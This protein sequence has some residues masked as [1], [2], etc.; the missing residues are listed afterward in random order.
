MSEFVL[1]PHNGLHINGTK[2]RRPKRRKNK[3]VLNLPNVDSKPASPPNPQQCEPPPSPKSFSP[4][5]PSDGCK[6]PTK[7]ATLVESENWSLRQTETGSFE[8]N[9]NSINNITDFLQTLN[10]MASE[11]PQHQHIE[12]TQSETSH[13]SEGSTLKKANR[14]STMP[15]INFHSELYAPQDKNSTVEWPRMKTAL[16]ALLDDCVHYHLQCMNPYFPVR[17]RRLLMKWYSGLAEPTKDP[18]VL[19]ISTYFVRHIFMHHMPP[20]FDKIRDMKV[21]DAVQTQLALYTREALSDCFDVAHPHHIYALCLYNMNSKVPNHLKAFY[22]TIAVR[23]AL[24]LNIA[25]RHRNGSTSTVVDDEVE[26]NN[27]IWWC[28]FQIDHFLTESEIISCSIIEPT[29]DNHAALSKLV[30]PSPCSLDEPDEV[31]GSHLWNNILKLWLIRRRLEQ[32]FEELDYDNPLAMNMMSDKV[33]R[34]INIWS[35]ELPDIFQQDVALKPE[36]YNTMA[37]M[38]FTMGIERC[39]NRILLHRMFLPLD[40]MDALNPLQHRSALYAVESVVELLSMRRAVIDIAYCQTWPGDLKRAIEMLMICVKFQD[41]TVMTRSKLGLMR[42]LRLLRSMPETE[43]KEDMC[44]T[45]I[46]RIEQILSSWPE[47]PITSEQTIT[48]TPSSFNNAAIPSP[49]ELQYP[50][51]TR[52]VDA[53]LYRN[54]SQSNI[55]MGDLPADALAFLDSNIANC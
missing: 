46:A 22:H 12:E 49:P 32:E 38:C 53:E 18:L 54:E 37:Q 8:V 15:F 25:P 52:W 2:P 10:L 3:D 51:Y 14:K 7:S 29:S 47:S 19:A 50:S 33:E 44:V 16:P 9:I 40:K 36:N 4:L 17:P 48:S 23:M 30:R 31:T 11:D 39:T 5:P 42:A 21:L 13:D 26:L 24:E 34:E 28:L 35:Q 41:T 45:N 20:A 6:S 55:I 1:G 27:R 43:W